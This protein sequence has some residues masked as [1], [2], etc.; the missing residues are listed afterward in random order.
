MERSSYDRLLFFKAAQ[1]CLKQSKLWRTF[2]NEAVQIRR[3]ARVYELPKSLYECTRNAMCDDI[4]M[5]LMPS[6][7]NPN[8]IPQKSLGDGNC[9]Y[10]SLS[11]ILFGSED[12]HIEMRVKTVIELAC[13]EKQSTDEKVFMEMAEYSYDGIMEYI[14]QVSISDEALVPNDIQ[15]SFRNETLTSAKDGQ[16][17]SIL[18]LLAI[19]NVIQKPLN[20]VYPKAQNPGVD[21]DVH[22]QVFFPIGQIYYPEN[23]DGMVTILWTH[24]SDT[25]LKGWKPNHFVSCFP[26]Y[27]N[28]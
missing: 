23:L 7:A 4:S 10:R 21:R 25:K 13:N 17:S 11:L 5:E 8:L 26:H 24:T 27:Q 22:N 2:V 15:A 3:E 12:N 6:D 20:S 18:H 28:R 1:S 14:V 19:C 16:Y 9:L